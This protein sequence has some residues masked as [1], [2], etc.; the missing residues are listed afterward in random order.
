MPCSFTLRRESQKKTFQFP[1]FKGGNDN[2]FMRAVLQTP[3]TWP[4]RKLSRLI[5]GVRWTTLYWRGLVQG[6]TFHGYL[7]KILK[8]FRLR[9]C[10]DITWYAFFHGKI[11]TK[12]A[13]FHEK[14]NIRPKMTRKT[15]PRSSHT[16]ETKY[17]TFYRFFRN[18]SGYHHVFSTNAQ[19]TWRNKLK[20]FSSTC[21]YFSYDVQPRIPLW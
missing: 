21:E 11:L 16:W 2:F 19:I 8:H 13:C 4:R 3:D 10:Y 14:L 6:L 1:V 20:L 17:R 7:V 15:S 12:Q 9:S 18:P 5:A